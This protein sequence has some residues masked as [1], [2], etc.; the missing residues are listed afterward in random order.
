[1][2]APLLGSRT[3]WKGEYFCTA[4]GGTVCNVMSV[5]MTAM[6]ATALTTDDY[7][8][9]HRASWIFT[10]LSLGATGAFT[11]QRFKHLLRYTESPHTGFNSTLLMINVALSIAS[12]SLSIIGE[13]CSSKSNFV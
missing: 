2:Q 9:H 5:F 3:G 10:C 8:E 1:M 6:V 13:T 7:C 11:F 12:I 4:V